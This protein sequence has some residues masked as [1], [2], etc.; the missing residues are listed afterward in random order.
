MAFTAAQIQAALVA[1]DERQE[2]LEERYDELSEE[3]QAEYSDEAFADAL[4]W[5]KEGVELPGVGLATCVDYEHINEDL[6]LVFKV[7]DQLFRITGYYSSYDADEW[8]SQVVEVE[9]REKIITVY[10]EI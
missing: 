8:D 1:F 9:A 7:G 3:E 2:E 10:E 6:K 5:R 4:Q